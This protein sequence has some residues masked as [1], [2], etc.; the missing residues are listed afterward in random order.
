MCCI[1]VLNSIFCKKIFNALNRDSNFNP[2]YIIKI[3]IIT[4]LLQNSFSQKKFCVNHH[5]SLHKIF[6]FAKNQFVAMLSNLRKNFSSYL[7]EI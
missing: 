6:L 5:F 3:C 7:K 1:C 4:F 2:L